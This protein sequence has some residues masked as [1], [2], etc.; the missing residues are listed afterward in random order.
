MVTMIVAGQVKREIAA[1]V[2]DFPD[3]SIIKLLALVVRLV[4]NAIH[5]INFCLV[6]GGIGFPNTY[7]LDS[8][9]GA[10][11]FFFFANSC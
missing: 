7:K 5:R 10:I 6:D 8:T 9:L 3:P 11:G 2:C 1:I 4:D